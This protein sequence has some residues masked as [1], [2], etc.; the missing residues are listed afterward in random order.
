MS[1]KGGRKFIFYSEFE[2]QYEKDII[3][4]QIYSESTYE[5]KNHGG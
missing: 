1:K 4:T 2:E 5:G 3:M